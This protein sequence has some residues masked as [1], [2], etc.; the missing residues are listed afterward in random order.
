MT[1]SS[2]LVIGAREIPLRIV[3]NRRARRYILR[4]AADGAVRAT[5]PRGGSIRGARA[6]ADRHHGWIAK[7]LQRRADHPAGP[8]AWSVG[9]EILYRGDPA[10]LLVDPDHR[11]DLVRFADE[12]IRV[13]AATTNLRAAVERHLWALARRELPAR[14]VE[15][16]AQHELAMA[17]VTIRNQR[18]KWGSC[19]PRRTI[20]LNWRLIQAPPVVRDYII[21]HELMHLREMN[22]SRKFWTL[23]RQACPACQQAEAWLK[24]HRGLLG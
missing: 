17:R 2:A 19:S 8:R 14:A 21:V 12:V 24:R 18:T 9:T 6:F 20:S 3:R 10:T 23:V 4:L 1:D 11:G 13:P 16:A 15:L 5:V 7:Q 22:H